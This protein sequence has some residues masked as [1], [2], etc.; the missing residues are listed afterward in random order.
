MR[1]LYPM[2]SALL[3]VGL[4]AG[5]MVGPDYVR[6]KPPADSRYTSG[7]A[8]AQTVAA[9]GP[10]GE[11]QSFQAGQAISADWWH[12]FHSSDLDRLVKEAIANNPTL[13]VA[14]ARLT[15][16]Q[17]VL[18]ADY[19]VLY[20][21]V[22]GSL[23]TQRQ[24][25]SAIRFGNVAEST[26]YTLYS[27]SV[28]VS[29]AVDF[30]GYARRV[31]E[32]QEATIESQ[33]MQL[34]AARLTLT[35]N[36]VN[37]AFLRAL[38]QGQIEETKAIIKGQETQVGLVEA[39]YRAGIVPYSDVLSLQA[40]LASTQ[41]TLPALEQRLS[42]ANHL[43]ATYLGKTPAEADLPTMHLADFT[44]PQELPLSLPS[45][46]VRQ[47]PDI[48]AAEAQLH[49]ANAQV[50]AATA[51]LYPRFTLNASYGQS[52]LSAGNLF[53]K[54]SNLW[55]LAGNLT[56]PLFDGGTLRAQRREAEA[57]FQQSLGSY[58]QTLLAA[59]AQVA[60]VLRALEHDAD[61][62]RI[63]QQAADY[64]HQSMSL[65]ELRYKAG[66]ASYIELLTAQRQDQQARI[67]VLQAQAQ[68]FQDTAA[69]FAALGGGWWHEGPADSEVAGSGGVLKK[70]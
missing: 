12:L 55:N 23:G 66:K 38:L 3:M 65:A 32:G 29:Y 18:K 50:G 51:A 11:A 46:L 52:S 63:Q 10:G 40:Q 47:R 22:A 7:P 45:E 1:R 31:A 17:E 24:K 62:L 13:D 58:R 37:T 68:R 19:G 6:P 4:L 20:P 36:V 48:L 27:A 57:A 26:I 49:A 15:Q 42:Q 60:D 14:R 70:R 9:R 64:A 44:L 21:Q 61:T 30:F 2:L 16:A 34:E 25:T 39:Q 5:C 59:F 54:S 43:L 28:N 8:P 67:A 41:A 53:D 69:L 33:R 56:A 35:G